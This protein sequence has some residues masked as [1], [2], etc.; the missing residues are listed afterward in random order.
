[1]KDGRLFLALVANGGVYEFEP[2]RLGDEYLQDGWRRIACQA[3]Q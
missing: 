3:E 2:S 1:M